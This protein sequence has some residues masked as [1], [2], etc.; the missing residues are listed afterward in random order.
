MMN[1]LITIL[2][3]TELSTIRLSIGQAEEFFPDE[4]ISEETERIDISLET[5]TAD[6][7]SSGV[8]HLF[9]DEIF[10]DPSLEKLIGAF[11]EE[12]GEEATIELLAENIAHAWG[13][14]YKQILSFIK[15]K[16]GIK[17]NS[18]ERDHLSLFKK[19]LRKF[20]AQYIIYETFAP[21]VD[22]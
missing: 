4:E 1:E 6:A 11:I 14:T 10:L 17:L 7:V 13:I 18:T 22:L 12:F 19:N 16:V 8:A 9:V 20:K 3:T 5:F 15:R 2:N 21:I